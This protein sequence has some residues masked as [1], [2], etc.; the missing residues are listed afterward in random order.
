M[1]PPIDRESRLLYLE[2][3]L[4][5]ISFC[6]QQSVANLDVRR[7]LSEGFGRRHL[8]MQTSRLFLEKRCTPDR[9]EP[10]ETYEATEVSIHL[11]AY[12]LNLRGALDNLAWATNYRFHI[13]PS[14]NENDRK[15]RGEVN[16]FNDK[17]I[18][19]LTHID[20]RLSTRLI[21]L[22]PWFKS[23]TALRD[24][25]AHRIP[26]YAPPS[27]IIEQEQ[28]GEIKRLN[29]LAS[30]PEHEL[31]G[32]RRIEITRR[33]HRVGKYAAV[34]VTSSPQ[35]LEIRRI[36]H[37]LPSDHRRYLGVSRWVFRLLRRAA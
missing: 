1:L 9:K 11:N 34:M 26:L 19:A 7:H 2:N 35:G 33:T 29:E 32:K 31:G 27:V 22:K 12:Y 30:R 23:F 6:V 17:F 25:A 10:L 16:L 8:M 14:A 13:I 20:L 24:P 15:L 18:V 5:A 37:Q 36:W 4:N 3:K 28:L 21:A